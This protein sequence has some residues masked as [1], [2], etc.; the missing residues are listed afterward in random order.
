L[1]AKKRK[2]LGLI[3]PAPQTG[4]L[5]RKLKRLFKSDDHLHISM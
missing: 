5:L 3:K 1:E 4:L 2:K